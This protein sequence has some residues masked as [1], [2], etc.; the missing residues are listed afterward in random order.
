MTSG[1]VI[2]AEDAPM[3]F[4]RN[5]MSFYLD[6]IDCHKHND[7]YSPLWET[8]AL[9]VAHRKGFDCS[10]LFDEVTKD[11]YA[12]PDFTYLRDTSVEELLDLVD[13]GESESNQTR[14]DIVQF[15]EV[16]TFICR[17]TCTDINNILRLIDAPAFAR[18]DGFRVI[19]KLNNKPPSESVYL[20]PAEAVAYIEQLME[21]NKLVG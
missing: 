9:F 19:V 5:L 18:I 21:S 1:R 4:T 2:R 14:L 3:R 10:M 13:S 8:F 15:D 17:K 16:V 7:R 20:G 11:G 12:H 6:S